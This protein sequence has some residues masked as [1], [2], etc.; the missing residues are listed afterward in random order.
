MIKEKRIAPYKIAP[1][2]NGNCYKFFCELSMALVCTTKPYKAETPEE[3]IRLAWENEGKRQ[4]NH[5]Q[6]CGKLV[7]DAMYN[8]DALECVACAPW[9]N[10]PE[11]CKFCG[12]K[13]SGEDA[14]CPKCGK[15]LIYGGR[16]NVEL[17]QE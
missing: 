16:I 7:M 15:L 1:D 3:E 10:T 17:L 4:F 11:Y 2:K 6:K 9:E 14:I 8:A 13:V 5:C 12:A